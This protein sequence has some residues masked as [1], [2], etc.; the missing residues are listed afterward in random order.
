MFLSKKDNSLNTLVNGVIV[1]KHGSHDQKTHGRKGGGRSGGGSTS[2][3]SQQY[4]ESSDKARKVIAERIESDL[5]EIEDGI[6]VLSSKALGGEDMKSYQSLERANNQIK[7][8]RKDFT[9]AAKLKGKE[10]QSKMQSGL[11]KIEGAMGNLSRNDFKG[12]D[13]LSQAL[14]DSITETFGDPDKTFETLG[15]DV[16]NLFGA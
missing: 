11:D 12:A 4:S 2:Q 5:L 10:Q 8:A 1:A 13:D 9:E 6:D 3:Q 15:L 16:D 14:Y 7:A